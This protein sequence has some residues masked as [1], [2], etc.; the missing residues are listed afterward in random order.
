MT[1][2]AKDLHGFFVPLKPTS[3][4][5][6]ILLLLAVLLILYACASVAVALAT[7]WPKYGSVIAPSAL[8]VGLTFSATFF[9]FRKNLVGRYVFRSSIALLLFV[10]G[11]YL[12][13]GP[14]VCLLARYRLT[15][16]EGRPLDQ[17][18][19][20]LYR[21]IAK[22]VVFA[23]EPFRNCAIKYVDWWTP[24]NACFHDYGDGISWG[25][26]NAQSFGLY[27]SP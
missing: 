12:S 13:L 6:H 27:H 7:A 16:P 18:V 21:P 14:A 19:H 26:P 4:M 17:A 2:Q 8:A 15:D 1:P 10:I 5:K 20:Y 23:P 9:W 24:S 3:N 25:F 11:L 22:N